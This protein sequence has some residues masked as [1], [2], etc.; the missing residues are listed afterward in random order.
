[1][2]ILTFLDHIST[3]TWP[4]LEHLNIVLPVD[5]TPAFQ[6]RTHYG[7]LAENLGFNFYV[8]AP[9]LKV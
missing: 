2:P 4:V 8:L 9:E 1:M 7:G 6:P 3:T 5:E